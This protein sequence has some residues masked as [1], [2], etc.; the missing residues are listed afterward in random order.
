L[1]DKTIHAVGAAIG[2]LVAIA[3]LGGIA[4]GVAALAMLA[5]NL[6]LVPT[7]EVFTPITFLQSFIGT[8]IIVGIFGF[9]K[10]IKGLLD[11]YQ[12]QIRM[13]LVDRAMKN[14]MESMG[15][16]PQSEEPKDDGG[17]VLRHFGS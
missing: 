6:V 17:D 16:A 14:M 2:I 12:E 8:V 10:A 7:I 13:K 5:W 4:V 15:A 3:T 11:G 1:K 9:V